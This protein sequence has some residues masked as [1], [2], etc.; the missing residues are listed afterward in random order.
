LVQF[1][2]LGPLPLHRLSHC[3]EGTK[4]S[5]I[6]E[7]C[8]LDKEGMKRNIPVWK[9]NKIKNKKQMIW[10]NAEVVLRRVQK[11]RQNEL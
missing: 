10:S 3:C 2:F 9:K 1:P 11:H 6:D 4:L 5:K 7:R 8:G